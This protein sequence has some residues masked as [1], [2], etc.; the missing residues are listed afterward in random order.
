MT[1]RVGAA[2]EDLKKRQEVRTRFVV[3]WVFFSELAWTLCWKTKKIYMH[4]DVTFL[5]NG[6]DKSGLSGLVKEVFN[7]SYEI[8]ICT[9]A[10]LATFS[11][12]TP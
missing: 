8:L 11:V 6:I 10:S 2:K 9:E 3:V 5:F 4:E 1:K 7:I 12:K